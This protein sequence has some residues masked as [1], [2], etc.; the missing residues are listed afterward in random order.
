MPQQLTPPSPFGLGMLLLALLPLAPLAAQRESAPDTA[1]LQRMLVAEDARGL[2]SEG[3]GP[4][5]D[6]LQQS[7]TLLRRLAVRGLGRLQRPELAARLVERLGDQ[8][9]SIRAE[10]AKGAAGK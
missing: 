9:P 3:I 2:G 4:M 5:L 8:V 7:D 10:A 6:G 1:F